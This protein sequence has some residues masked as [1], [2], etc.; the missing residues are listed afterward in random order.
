MSDLQ[1]FDTLILGSGQGGKQLAWHLAR[2]GARVAVAERRWV[3]GSC[4]AVACLPSKASVDDFRIASA[5]MA[6][7]NRTT[8]ARLIPNVLFTDPPLA[9]VGLTELDA[10]RQGV[11]VRVA[12]LPMTRVL[13]TLATDETDG[14]MK[15][16][17]SSNDDRILGFTMLGSEAGEVDSPTVSRGFPDGWYEN[18]SIGRS[19]RDG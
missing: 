6:G 12:K 18:C 2:A 13:R 19:R 7:G 14:F 1:R 10:Q 5:N 17:V 8:R 16:L 9:H 4:P 15:V 11:P 3:G